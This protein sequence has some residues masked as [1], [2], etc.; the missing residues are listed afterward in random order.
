MNKKCKSS[1]LINKSKQMKKQKWKKDNSNNCKMIKKIKNKFNL[2]KKIQ[3][4][5]YKKKC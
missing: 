2:N 3:K 4:M 1:K 5:N